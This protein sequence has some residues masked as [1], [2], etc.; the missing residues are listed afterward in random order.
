MSQK[1]PMRRSKGSIRDSI[2]ELQRRK[3]SKDSVVSL[4]DYR[5]TRKLNRDKTILVVDQDKTARNGVQR[6]LESER[7]RVETADDAISL[8]QVIELN[9]LDLILLD[10]DLP[11]VNGFELCALL[12]THDFLKSIPIIMTSEVSS[13][14]LLEQGFASGCDDFVV[15]PFGADKM[16]DM[17]KKVFM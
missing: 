1:P 7:F 16:A 6:Y 12:K 11:W 15:K 5:D 9:Q 13:Q 3:I 8:S 10:V 17:M 2:I 4:S 14:Q